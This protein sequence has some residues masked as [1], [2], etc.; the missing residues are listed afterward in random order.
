VGGHTYRSVLEVNLV[1][2]D[3]EWKVLRI[4][5]T[6][7]DEK[8]VPPAV[9]CLECVWHGDI[10]DKYTAVCTSV[11]CNTQALEALLTCS[12]PNLKYAPQIYL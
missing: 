5:W 4:S 8:L 7:L 10:K 12:V 1:T 11:E 3:N 6:C 9:K 2:N